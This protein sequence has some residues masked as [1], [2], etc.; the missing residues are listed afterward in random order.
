VDTNTDEEIDEE[1]EEDEESLVN[2]VM[3]LRV[4]ENVGTFLGKGGAGRF[5]RSQLRGIG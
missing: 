1:G 5:S 4:P 3:N 2:M